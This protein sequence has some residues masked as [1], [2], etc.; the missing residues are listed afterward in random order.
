ML[1]TCNS[2][3]I[4]QAYIQFLNVLRSL[5]SGDLE[6]IAHLH[7]TPKLRWEAMVLHTTP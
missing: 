2:V 5:S 3:I 4:M 1:V 7:I 6:V